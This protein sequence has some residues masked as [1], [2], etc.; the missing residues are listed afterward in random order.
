[1]RAV[2]KA[3]AGGTKDTVRDLGPSPHP[4][5]HPC[6]LLSSLCIALSSLLAKLEDKAI[7]IHN[8]LTQ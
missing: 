4:S 3:E 8:A 7:N 1:M 2:A 6:A 5:L